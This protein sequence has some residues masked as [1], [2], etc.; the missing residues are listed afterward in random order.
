LFVSPIGQLS[1]EKIFYIMTPI[2]MQLTLRRTIPVHLNGRR[3]RRLK[4]GT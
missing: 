4:N 3:V 2:K 1:A